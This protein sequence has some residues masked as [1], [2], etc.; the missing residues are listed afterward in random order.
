MALQFIGV[1][2][3][4]RGVAPA[5]QVNPSDVFGVGTAEM[6]VKALEKF[7]GRQL[8]I[9]ERVWEYHPRCRVVLA[10]L[11][12]S[13]SLIHCNILDVL[14]S[15]LREWAQREE[16]IFDELRDAVLG[17]DLSITTDSGA[18]RRVR[19]GD[20]GDIHCAGPPCVDYSLAG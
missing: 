17:A 14:P 6:A 3:A 16:P 10:R 1:A 20:L 7:T 11:G 15:D 8:V 18:R 12:L 4:L 19:Q 5:F 9:H 2:Q 13:H